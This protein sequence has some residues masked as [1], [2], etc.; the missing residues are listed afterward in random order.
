[1]KYPALEC[2][3]YNCN[4]NIRVVQVLKQK[5]KE[6]QSMDCFLYPRK[7]ERYEWDKTVHCNFTSFPSVLRKD[8][9]C[10]GW[11]SPSPPGRTIPGVASR[12]QTYRKQN[13]KRQEREREKAL[14]KERT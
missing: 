12:T 8:I 10:S 5:D 2:I 1:M 4:K 11:S 14:R 7:R 13:R 6:N 3:F 9:N